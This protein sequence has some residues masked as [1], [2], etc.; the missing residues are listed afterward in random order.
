[1][2]MSSAAQ[3]IANCMHNLHDVLADYELSFSSFFYQDD[4]LFALLLWQLFPLFI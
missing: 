2:C 3:P 1:M 4:F